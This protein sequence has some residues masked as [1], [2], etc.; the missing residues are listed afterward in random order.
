MKKIIKKLVMFMLFV[1]LFALMAY[2]AYLTFNTYKKYK[3]EQ[4]SIR[5]STL[6][7]QT[8]NLT[9]KISSEE[10]DSALFL[11]S[12]KYSSEEMMLARKNTDIAFEK[13][14]TESKKDGTYSNISKHISKIKKSIQYARS[15]VDNLNKNY[16]N[17]YIKGYQ[18]IDKQLHSITEYFSK[19]LYSTQTKDE[20]KLFSQLGNNFSYSSLEASFIL[21][22]QDTNKPMSNKDTA[23]WKLISNKDITVTYTNNIKKK[24]L[25]NIKK[26]I[27]AKSTKIEIESIHKNFVASASNGIYNINKQKLISTY[28]SF[29]GDLDRAQNVLT[30]DISNKISIRINK[31]KNK[32]LI[33]V[34]YIAFIL[35]TIFMLFYNIIKSNKNSKILEDTFEDIGLELDDNKRKELQICVANRDIHGTY[36]LMAETIK[37]ANHA[38]DLFLANMSHEIRTPLNGI[39]GFTELLKSTK[40]DNNQKDFMEVIEDSSENLL[41]IVNDILD[42]SKIKADKI[43]LEEIAF[44]ARERFESS[45]ESYGAKAAQKDIELGVYIDPNIPSSLLGDPTK[46]SQILTNLISNAV[47]FT[48]E[49]G[50]INVYIDKIEESPDITRVKFTVEDSGVGISEKQKSHIFEEFTQ[51]DSSTNRK[52]GGTGL[53]LAISSKLISLMDGKLD[54][55]SVVGEGSTFFFTLDMKK[56][57]KTMFVPQYPDY[58]DLKIGLLLP[59]KTINRQTDKNLAKYIKFFNT[60]L[61]IYSIDNIFD[62]SKGK[63]PNILFIDN[64]HMSGENNLENILEIPTK[65]V[66]ITNGQ[67]KNK[68]ESTIAKISKILYKPI[69]FTKIERILYELSNSEHNNINTNISKLNIIDKKKFKGLNVLVAEDNIIN[70]KLIS[71]I[72]SDFGMNV[73]LADNG[74]E[75]V[76]LRRKENNI[77]IIFMDIQMPILGG[78]DASKEILNY[79]K[80]QGKKHVPIIALTANALQGDR[81]KYISAGMDDYVTKPIDVQ[82]LI[83]MLDK[84]VIKDNNKDNINNNKK[85]DIIE[86]KNEINSINADETPVVSNSVLIYKK[87]ILNSNIYKAIITN[88]GFIVDIVAEEDKFLNLLENNK[89][90]YVLVGTGIIKD[91]NDCLIAEYI[92]DKGAIPIYFKTTGTKITN[93]CD[94]IDIHA[95]KED[96]RDLLV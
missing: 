41:H 74:E 95:S 53:G 80:S 39:V 34:G 15:H 26:I 8:Q 81:E 33:Y 12:K 83:K 48:P 28:K 96:F 62:M 85:Q 1:F 69:N 61:E 82:D 32:A 75:A 57:D 55:N 37:E 17:I 9:N 68:S 65:I 21:L 11:I 42:L 46:V 59:E 58:S 49:G 24:I 89:Y 72:F 52:Y 44:N 91:N 93:C 23:T 79:E 38:K 88:M 45:I 27:D 6:M 20:L 54:I 47:K 66:V 78:V 29:L 35:L 63:L 18:S 73:I 36:K 7:N 31:I 94:E 16:E 13:I 70:Q 5:V 76:N 56:H 4:K 25:D 40:L 2:I 22:K 30:T 67:I 64:K 86:L 3:N 14:I 77:D 71:I 84:Y 50:T 10:I 60:N 92:R 87:S 19:Y 51:A 43:D 90:K